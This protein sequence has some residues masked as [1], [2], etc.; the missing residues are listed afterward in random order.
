MRKTHP[1][2]Y[3]NTVEGSAGTYNLR[4]SR[5]GIVIVSGHGHE[6]RWALYF[7]REGWVGEHSALF[8][9]VRDK[10]QAAGFI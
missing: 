5:R 3:H 4:V 10:L 8:H 9:R 7:Y 6:W 1:A 2:L